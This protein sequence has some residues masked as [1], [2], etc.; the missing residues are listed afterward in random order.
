M[1]G[2][3]VLPFYIIFNLFLNKIIM[4]WLGLFTKIKNKYILLSLQMFLTLSLYIAFILPNGLLK[5]I[6]TIVGNYYLGIIIYTSI[7]LVLLL[8][9]KFIFKKIKVNR[10]T[11]TIVGFISILL[12]SFITIYGTINSDII[13]TTRYEVDINKKCSIE[14]LNIV[15]IAD[16]HLGYNKG[17]K[18]I[19]NMVKKIN[20]EN[21]DILII[22]GDIFDNNYDSL[23]KPKEMIKEL[24]KIR[25][26][27][28]VYAVYGN[29]DVK[30]KILLGFTFKDKKK[31]NSDIR[32]DKFLSDANIKILKDD[33][34]NL[35]NSIYIYGRQDYKKSINRK[36]VSEVIK[37]LDKENPIIV[38]DHQPKELKEL[39]R[40]GVDLDLSGH[41]HDGQI[42]PL[43]YLI[44]LAFDNSYGI[45]KYADMTSIVTSG[46]G[47]YGPNLRVLTKAEITSIKV[48]FKSKQ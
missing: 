45:K 4:N 27:Y 3:I 10:I 9:L 1:I 38:I 7:I 42:F 13:H 31:K 48:N 29:H 41:T 2:I 40:A 12:I 17:L 26:K 47:L 43:N 34:I 20:K 32:M 33:Y 35:D 25:T 15:M 46:V 16:L 18:M 14:N 11:Y 8:L 19:K 22:A 6:L 21:P 37:K 36:K 5:R 44:K 28:G 39:A 24:K 30:E 23:D